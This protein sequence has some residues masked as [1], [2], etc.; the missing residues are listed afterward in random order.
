MSP[1]TIA[2]GIPHAAHRPERVATLAR[3]LDGLGVRLPP[4]GVNGVAIL[5]KAVEAGGFRIFDR[6]CHH[7]EWSA[8][9]WDWQAETGASHC[10]VMQD[11]VVP[12]PMFGP[13]LLAM[14]TAVPDH[15]IALQTTHP[16]ARECARRG[17][18]WM[19]TSDGLTGPQYVFPGPVMR[20]FCAWRINNLVRGAATRITEDGL[21]NCFLLDTGRRAWHPVPAIARHDTSAASTNALKPGQ[22]EHAK[23]PFRD[24][25]VAWPDGD[26]G[27]WAFED[28]IRP[29][30]WRPGSH[31]PHLGM[32]YG[33]THGEARRLVTSFDDAKHARAASDKPPPHIARWMFQGT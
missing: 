25:S 12:G 19:T 23:Q 3:L 8:E 29:E 17:Y 26:V 7:S 6:K 9:L 4:P 1:I 21:V 5:P 33:D 28:L 30:F 18:R 22:I 13:A 10:L 2:L 27:G 15:V 31:V 16:F 11:D 20:E 14:V 24:V 32:Q